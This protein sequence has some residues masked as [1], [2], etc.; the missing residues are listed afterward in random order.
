M[1]SVETWATGFGALAILLSLWLIV[2]LCRY[3]IPKL[4]AITSGKESRTLV[5]TVTMR[6]S[7]KPRIGQ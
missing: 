4:I 5:L 6:K 1:P 7:S 3:Y 2:R